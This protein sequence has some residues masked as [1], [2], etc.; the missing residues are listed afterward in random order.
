MR[1]SHRRI[2]EIRGRGAMLGMVLA[3]GETTKAVAKRAIERGVL[4]GWTLHSDNLIRL[5]PPLNIPFDVLDEALDTLI[6]MLEE[7]AP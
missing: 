3:N 6:E 4:T 2:L 1:L 7:K 5:A